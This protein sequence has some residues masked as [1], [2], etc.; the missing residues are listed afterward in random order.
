[1]SSPPMGT[2][3]V[4]TRAGSP[5]GPDKRVRGVGGGQRRVSGARIFGR[6]PRRACAV[7]LVLAAGGCGGHP[8]PASPLPPGV[9]PIGPGP[10]YHPPLVPLRIAGCRPGLGPRFGVHLELFAGRFVVLFPAG[11]GT[12]PPRRWFA[13]R[14]EHAACYGPLVTID[15]TGLVLLRP[16]VRATVGDVF[17]SW[18]RPLRLGFRGR[19]RAFVGGREVSGDPRAIPLRRHDEIVLEI[20][21]FVPPHARYRF[22]SGF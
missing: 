11:I 3:L 22:P 9:R 5:T 15:P 1:R 20:G 10:R 18:G 2:V 16:G 7:R 6:R 17:A 19:M 21:G 4:L 13:G 8:R 12:R 14:V